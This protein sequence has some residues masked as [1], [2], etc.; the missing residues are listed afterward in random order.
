MMKY[1]LDDIQFTF[2][3]SHEQNVNNCQHNSDGFSASLIDN[4]LPKSSGKHLLQA[5][6]NGSDDS[7]KVSTFVL[8]I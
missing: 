2:K 4:H 7:Y 3:G 8:H 5:K 1:G 6:E